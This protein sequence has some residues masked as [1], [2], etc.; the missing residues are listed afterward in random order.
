MVVTAVLGPGVAIW[1]AANNQHRSD[2]AWCEVLALTDRS[3]RAV[4]VAA[5][6]D[7]GAA[8]AV[9]VVARLEAK[10]DCPPV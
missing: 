4:A 2:Q 5:P 7:V 6:S 9:A 10:F 1:V 8:E 3:V